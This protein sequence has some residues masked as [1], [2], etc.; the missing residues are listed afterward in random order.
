M[1]EKTLRTIHRA[2]GITLSP[3]FALQALTGLFIT[4]DVVFPGSFIKVIRNIHHGGGAGGGA[5]R[6]VVGAGLV[7]ML[8]TGIWIALRILARNRKQV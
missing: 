3:F 6:A 5:Y 1:K 7:W 8:A 2:V 4:F